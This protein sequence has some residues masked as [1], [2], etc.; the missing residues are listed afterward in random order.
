[1]KCTPEEAEA[2]ANHAAISKY[3]R[4]EGNEKVFIFPDAGCC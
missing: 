1:M 3:S 4:N 2:L